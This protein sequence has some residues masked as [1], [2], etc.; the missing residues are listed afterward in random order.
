LITLRSDS[1][2]V[3]PSAEVPQAISTGLLRQNRRSLRPVLEA[4][5]AWGLEHINGTEAR[6][7]VPQESR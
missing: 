4:L 3:I 6:V 1:I 5:N 7:Q 2:I